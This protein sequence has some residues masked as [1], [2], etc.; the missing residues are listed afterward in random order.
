MEKCLLIL[1][2]SFYDE[3]MMFKRN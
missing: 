3:T 1:D 2:A